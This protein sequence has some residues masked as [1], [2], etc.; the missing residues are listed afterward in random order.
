MKLHSIFPPPSIQRTFE[1][2]KE[3]ITS[4][5]LT[6]TI[7][8]SISGTNSGNIII[9]NLRPKTHPFQ[10]TGHKGSIT[11][12]SINPTETLLASS[13]SSDGIIRLWDLSGKSKLLRAHPLPVRSVDF[14]NNGNYILTG[15]NDKT[16]RIY[17]LFPKIKYIASYKGHLNWVNCARFSP[18]NKLVG[19]SGND[20]SICVFDIMKKTQIYKF[21]ENLNKIQSCRFSPDGTILTSCGNDGK[22]KLFDIRTGNCVQYY[23]IHNDIINSISYHPS[24]YFI[25]SGSNDNSIK[26]LDLKIGKVLFS[27]NGH[28]DN[29]NSVSF[30]E[31]GDYFCSGGQ[32]SLVNI[33]ESNIS[34]IGYDTN[35]RRKFKSQQSLRKKIQNNSKKTVEQIKK[36][37]DNNIHKLLYEDNIRNKPIESSHKIIEKGYLTIETSRNVVKKSDFKVFRQEKTN[38]KFIRFP[39]EIVSSFDK[40]LFNTKKMTR[41][42][43]SLDKAFQRLEK[44]VE[45]SKGS[46]NSRD[47]IKIKNK[48]VVQTNIDGNFSEMNL[49][50][51][52]L[53]HLNTLAGIN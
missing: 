23:P 43:K 48:N 35:L 49:K 10:L 15:S 39:K 26:L 11:D 27:V 32:D 40:V 14:S 18:D 33:W 51:Y 36:K 30:S 34:Y 17:S 8:R 50:F 13:S 53:A 41:A 29:V 24:G 20:G 12:L 19:S 42:I 37:Y 25:I 38:N 16:V 5:L 4:T 21:I 45:S 46:G 2:N 47:K 22:I 52:N 44:K 28:I 3:V 31:S 7:K 6:S 1:F 9:W